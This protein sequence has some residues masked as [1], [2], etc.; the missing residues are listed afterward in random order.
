M[1]TDLVLALH[2]LDQV[3]DTVGVAELV[4]VPGD[5]LDESVAQLDSGLGVKDGRVAVTDKVSGD[6]L[7]L[8]VV[9]DALQRSLGG[10]L[11]LLL[12]LVVGGW[13]GQAAGQ[14]NDGNVGG[15]HA[16]SHS[17][18]LAVQGWNDL[19]DGLGGTGGG[20]D[21]VLGG[22]TTV[23]PQLAGRT[24]N[25]LLGGGGGVDGGH[26]T[27]Q[28]SEVVVDDLGQWSQAV[29]GAGSVR[30]DLHR[31][32]VRVQVDT[33]D[34]HRGISRRGR[35]DDLLGTTLQVSGRLCDG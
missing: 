29:G 20:R 16:E 33:D 7:L 31:G 25:G 4:V 14:I 8:G 19:A 27:L 3:D 34:E 2:V 6:D 23:T 9:E 32:V 17:G 22:T 11:D 26:Q 21:D 30:D 13:L 10:L 15:W 1:L 28:D 35:D 24:V 5:E 18:E 12:D